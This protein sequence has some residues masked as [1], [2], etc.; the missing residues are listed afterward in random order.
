MYIIITLIP[1]STYTPINTHFA[2]FNMQMFETPKNV[3]F[4]Y[5]Q[6]APQNKMSLRS[7]FGDTF[8]RFC[9]FIFN[10]GEM[11]G[12]LGQDYRKGAGILDIQWENPHTLLACGYDSFLR[13]WDTRVNY[14]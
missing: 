6:G 12:I 11:I 5:T 10:R 13:L 1:S 7:T 9:C 3:T 8:K 4:F 2:M 14:Q